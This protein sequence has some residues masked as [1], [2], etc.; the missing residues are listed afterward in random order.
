MGSWSVNLKVSSRPASTNKTKWKPNTF[1]LTPTEIC[2]WTRTADFKKTHR[3]ATAIFRFFTVYCSSTTRP[4]ITRLPAFSGLRC[5]CIACMKYKSTTDEQIIHAMTTHFFFFYWMMIPRE[6]QFVRGQMIAT[7]AASLNTSRHFARSALRLPCTWTQIAQKLLRVIFQELQLK[8]M[9]FAC[10]KIRC[11]FSGE[12]GRPP[13]LDVL[14]KHFLDLIFGRLAA[15]FLRRA[16]PLLS[17]F[18]KMLSLS[19]QWVLFSFFLRLL[20]P[21]WTD[22]GWLQRACYRNCLVAGFCAVTSVT[23]ATKTYKG[24][25]FKAT[26]STSHVLL[27]FCKYNTSNLSDLS[28]KLMSVALQHVYGER[29]KGP[30]KKGSQSHMTQCLGTS[31]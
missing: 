31:F 14:L 18:P 24:F 4:K 3:L 17:R 16:S 2:V 20:M 7:I 5:I 25:N 11:D 13:Q 10:F 12:R 1:T 23:N 28:R 26:P 21:I 15:P 8:S 27:V 22:W 19:F 6:S 30:A 9:R 29:L